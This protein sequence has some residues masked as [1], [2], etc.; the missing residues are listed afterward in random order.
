MNRYNP[1]RKS[2]IILLERKGK[3][4]PVYRDA[5]YYLSLGSSKRVEVNLSKISRLSG[6]SKTFLVPGKV[7]GSGSIDSKVVVGA[8]SFSRKAVEKIK[9][10]GGEALTIEEFVKRYPE[11]RGVVIVR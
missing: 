10:K 5:S 8:F 7:L 3:S 11:G 6:V 2:S 1:L 9:E 4:Y